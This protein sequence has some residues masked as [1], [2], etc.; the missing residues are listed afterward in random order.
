MFHLGSL[1]F[2]GLVYAFHIHQDIAEEWFYFW[3][4]SRIKC[5]NGSKGFVRTTD[6]FA[7]LWDYSHTVLA[8]YMGTICDVKFDISFGCIAE[9][10]S[11]TITVN[12]KWVHFRPGFSNSLPSF[13]QIRWFSSDV[14]FDVNS[15]TEK[16][17]IRN[18]WKLKWNDEIEKV[19]KKYF[20][21]F[22]AR[23]D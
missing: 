7:W 2:Q 4:Q 12:P 6:T 10:K 19:N 11:T 14:I 13:L 15:F 18:D 1:V 23:V 22:Q 17:S 9:Q 3:F 21:W 5:S 16:K 20:P 8:K